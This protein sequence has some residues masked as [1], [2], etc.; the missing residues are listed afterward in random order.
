MLR[1]APLSSRSSAFL[2]PMLISKVHS[3][4]SSLFTI[5]TVQELTALIA[6]TFRRSANHC[7]FFNVSVSFLLVFDHYASLAYNLALDGMS[8][9]RYIYVV[10]ISV[11]TFM[12]C[13][14]LL[15][16]LNT[17]VGMTNWWTAVVTRHCLPILTYIKR[18]L[19]EAVCPTI[20]V[21]SS[22]VSL[23]KM[24]H[25]KGCTPFKLPVCFT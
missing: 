18:T 11:N 9:A 8:Q 23:V 10:S 6:L 22:L 17:I 5:G 1:E 16:R 7:S 14:S 3:S 19:H 12:L 20:S 25:C 13:L 15:L 2:P 24:V 21:S 4:L